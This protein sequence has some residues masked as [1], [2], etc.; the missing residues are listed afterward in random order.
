MSPQMK[1]FIY[2]VVLWRMLTLVMAPLQKM[3]CIACKI[4]LS[5]I[6]I[7]LNLILVS[8]KP[9]LEK[10]SDLVKKPCST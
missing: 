2:I 10:M 6:I 7:A 1:E 9:S 8:P 3:T 5:H 4:F